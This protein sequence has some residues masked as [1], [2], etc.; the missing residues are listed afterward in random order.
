MHSGRG[1]FSSPYEHEYLKLACLM[2]EETAAELLEPDARG[3][4]RNPMLLGAK[5]VSL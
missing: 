5:Q 3:E 1:S 4:K 2:I